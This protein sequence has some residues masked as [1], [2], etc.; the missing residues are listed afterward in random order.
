MNIF[1]FFP[2]VLTGLRPFSSSL[3]EPSSS[4]YFTCVKKIDIRK[5]VHRVVYASSLWNIYLEDPLQRKVF[6]NE[7]IQYIREYQI[8]EFSKNVRDKGKVTTKYALEDLRL[9][10]LSSKCKNKLAKCK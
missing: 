1:I 2:T 3:V 7:V 8:L 9:R 10:I 4:M 6:R 5:A